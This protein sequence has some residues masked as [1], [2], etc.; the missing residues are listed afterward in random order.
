MNPGSNTL[1]MLTIDP[2]N[3]TKLTVVGTPV[4]IP[5]DFPN[6]VAASKKHNL[7]CVGTT[8]AKSGVSCASFSDNGVKE[9]DALRP[10]DLGQTTPPT[11]PTNSV[12]HL[13]FSEDESTLFCTVKGDPPSNKTGFLAAFKVGGGCKVSS[14]ST[15][16]V[17][18]SPNGTAV[19]F[20]SAPI[21]GTSN[22]FATDAAFGAAILAVDGNLDS[23]LVAKQAI[24]GQAATCWVTLSKRTKTAFVTDVLKPRLVEMSLDDA[25][26][27]SDLDLS[28]TGISGM[29]DLRSA[30]NFVYALAPGNGTSEAQVIVVD[31][32]GGSGQ[33]KLKQ[34]FGLGKL[35]AGPRA[36][37]M[38][39]LA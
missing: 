7:V 39:I 38:A 28:Q 18:T 14:L 15:T 11:G 9:M 32:S 10:F 20:G 34:S 30:G 5:G 13:F 33:G 21:P 22:I 26:I 24:D 27:V 4:T 37:G 17:Q 36:Q 31:V 23:T 29:I 3:P 25:H 2:S 19:L 12:S 35:G 16:D 6:T 1:T 8:G